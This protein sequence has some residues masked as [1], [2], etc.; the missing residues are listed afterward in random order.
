MARGEKKQVAGEGR[1]R[2]RECVHN[3]GGGWW[4]WG[5]GQGLNTQNV[6]TRAIRKIKTSQL[7]NDSKYKHHVI[8]KN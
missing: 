3:R 2:K 7:Q 6:K 4:R 5:T 8:Y 1:L